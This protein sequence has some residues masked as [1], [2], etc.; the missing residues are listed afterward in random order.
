MRNCFDAGRAR[1]VDFG[2]SAALLDKM[3]E[4]DIG[5]EVLVVLGSSL[6]L[7]WLGRWLSIPLVSRVSGCSMASNFRLGYVGVA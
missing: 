7:G 2:G 1:G 4:N 5:S 3:L 6:A